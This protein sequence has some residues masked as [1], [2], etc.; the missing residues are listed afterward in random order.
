MLLLEGCAQLA[1]TAFGE[2][3]GIE[4]SGIA[5]YEVSFS[6]FVE[7]GIPTTLTADVDRFD[8]AVA[9]AQPRVRIVISQNGQACGT[10]AL[11]LAVPTAN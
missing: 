2:S 1:L 7:T 4:A 6:Q 11:Q 10:V 9:G 8:I 5:G 3:S